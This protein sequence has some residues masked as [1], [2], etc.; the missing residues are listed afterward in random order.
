MNRPQPG[1]GCRPVL[2]GATGRSS[3]P[4]ARHGPVV[5]DDTPRPTVRRDD[6]LAALVLTRHLPSEVRAWRRAGAISRVR[7]GA[8]TIAG[9]SRGAALD[10][11]ERASAYIEAVAAQLRSDY[12]FSHES[13]AL[14]WGCGIVGLSGRTHVT[15]EWCSS[16]RGDPRLVRHTIDLPPAERTVWRG[17]PVTTLA[18]TAV[19]CA[20]SMTGRHGLVVVDSALRL[21]ADPEEIRSILGARAGGR[22]VR[23]ARI[24]VA[25]A[26]QKSESPGES[27]V[28]WEILDAGLPTPELQVVVH[29]TSGTY[30]LDLAWSAAR[31]AVEFDGYVKYSGGFGAAPDVVFAE[32]R[33]QDALEAA[34]WIVVRVTW[35]DLRDPGPTIARIRRALSTRLS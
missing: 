21:G 9:P 29:T 34:G 16:T 11:E 33:R 24:V 31:V 22:G 25:R 6:G 35:D 3:R 1:R 18:R 14:V 30:R 27:L 19:D 12:W 15:Q 10:R 23:R 4:P 13:A 8:Y 7:R 26:D 32:K 17:L 20:T 2:R 28:R 5:R